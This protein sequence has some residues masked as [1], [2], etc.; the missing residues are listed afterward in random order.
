VLPDFL[1]PDTV[2]I[3]EVT[4][5]GV[6]RKVNDPRNFQLPLLE[7]D[8]GKKVLVRFQQTEKLHKALSPIAIKDK[9][10]F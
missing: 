8:Q 3:L 10:H 6:G 2:E 9:R 5:D 1:G 4:V 7:A